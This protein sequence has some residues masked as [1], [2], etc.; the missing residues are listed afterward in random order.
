MRQLVHGVGERKVMILS[1]END[2]NLKGA[3][4]LYVEK[5]HYGHAEEENRDPYYVLH[6]RLPDGTVTARMY[7]P[8][9]MEKLE[10]Y[11]KIVSASFN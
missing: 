7:D 6:L 11:D 2:M 3:K 10:A 8:A 5:H 9:A 1:S 4:L